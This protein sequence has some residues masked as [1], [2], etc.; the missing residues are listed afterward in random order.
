MWA[1][2]AKAV[3]SGG[4]Q[5][6][7]SYLSAD[8]AKDASKKAYKRA[9]EFAQSGIQW[10]V[11]DAN[12]AGINPYFALGAPTAT[13]SDSGVG[14]DPVGEAMNA[15]G[16]N[17]GRAALANNDGLSKAGAQMQAL[18]LERAGLENEYL[19]SKIASEN[20]LNTQAGS[21][22]LLPPGALFGGVDT[23]PNMNQRLQARHGEMADVLT[24]PQTVLEVLR[25]PG[26]LGDPAHV[27][28]LTAL[29]DELSRTYAAAKKTLYDAYRW[30]Y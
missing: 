8:A 1:E 14:I 12:A 24:A 25:R 30:E 23:D 29:A 17:I 21:P 11:S 2:V 15:M 6:L 4:L 5:A 28:S 19:R 7:G 3:A 26:N 18:E 9:K 13:Y 22:P 10:K 16:Q 27:T 20:R